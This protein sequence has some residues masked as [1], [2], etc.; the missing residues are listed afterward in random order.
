[1]QPTVSQVPPI[2]RVQIRGI[3]RKIREINQQFGGGDGAF[4][5][6]VQFL[7]IILPRH[8]D[9]FCLE[10]VE[11]YELGDA[12]GLTLPDEN[13]I[14]IRE[15]V[16]LGACDGYGRDRMTMAH[17]LGHYVLHSN[18]GFARRIR[19]AG[20][21][22]KYESSEWQ[23]DDFGGELLVSADHIRQCRTPGE[24]ALMFGVSIVAAQ[25]QWRVFGREGL[26][27]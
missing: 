25:Y 7:D 24:A 4:F 5:D 2:K 1:M 12:H 20:S 17:E 26:T 22:P 14:L 6:I 8:C 3:A 16:Y 19:G 15:D 11:G 23:A 13:R 9:S 18:L 27:G 10:V 21:I